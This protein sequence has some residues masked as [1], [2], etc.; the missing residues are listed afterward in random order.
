M[1]RLM[2]LL[3]LA[4]TLSLGLVARPALA[5]T[6]VFVN[7]RPLSLPQ[8]ITVSRALG[9]APAPG[10]YWYDP[11]SGNYGRVGGSGGGDRFWSTSFSAGNST[12]DNSQGY[13][14]VPGYGP[15]SYGM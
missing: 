1:K 14:S 11:R 3:F 5:G 6:G 15:V 9:Y 13:V 2:T 10:Y 12:A 4:I 7:G 8:L